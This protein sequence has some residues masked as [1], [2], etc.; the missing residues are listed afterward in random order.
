RTLIKPSSRQRLAIA[1]AAAVAGNNPAWPL[2]ANSGR[3]PGSA[4]ARVSASRMR[5]V[6]LSAKKPSV[7]LAHRLSVARFCLFCPPDARPSDSSP[8]SLRPLR[9][10]LKKTTTAEDAEAR[11]EEKIFFGQFLP[12]HL[13]SGAA[14]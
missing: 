4:A 1:R 9:L 2:P 3:P 8:R 5:S 14:G 12:C 10:S 6:D 7:V 11:R 13:V